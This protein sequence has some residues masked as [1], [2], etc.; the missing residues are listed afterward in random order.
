[1]PRVST[2]VFQLFYRNSYSV[3][4][5][6]GFEILDDGTSAQVRDHDRGNA[7]VACFEKTMK[8]KVPFIVIL[9]RWLK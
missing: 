6:N 3:S 4:S 1:M 8:D 5:G 7:N 2:P 9:G